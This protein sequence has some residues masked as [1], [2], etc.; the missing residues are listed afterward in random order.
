MILNPIIPRILGSLVGLLSTIGGLV[1]LWGSEDAMQ[2]LIHWIGEE[3][4]LGASFVIRQADG[5]TLLTNPGAMVR[6]MS[7]IWVVGL[8]QI[9]AGVSLL[10]RSATKARHE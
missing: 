6:W 2:V 7:L 5:S 9:A 1:L 10:K 3:R 4:A 8:S